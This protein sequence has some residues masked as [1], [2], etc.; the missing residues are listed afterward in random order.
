MTKSSDKEGI[1][2]TAREDSYKGNSIRLSVG[3]TGETEARREWH[4]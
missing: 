3:F 2:K 1:L 4:D